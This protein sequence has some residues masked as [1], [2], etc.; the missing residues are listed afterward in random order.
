MEEIFRAQYTVM[1]MLPNVAQSVY[2]VI[3]PCCNFKFLYLRHAENASYLSQKLTKMYIVM[4]IFYA[5]KFEN[6]N[7]SKQ[8]SVCA[9]GESARRNVTK[10]KMQKDLHL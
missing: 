9:R 7:L 1:C 4:H 2:D 10:R 6:T 3:Y 8:R 5:V